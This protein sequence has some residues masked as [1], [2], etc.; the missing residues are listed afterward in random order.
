MYLAINLVIQ[1]LWQWIIGIVMM[2]LA[3][4]I[5]FLVTQEIWISA[6]RDLINTRKKQIT[7]GG[8][9]L[10]AVLSFFVI[11]N[12]QPKNLFFWHEFTLSVWQI[13]FICILSLGML[14]FLRQWHLKGI[15]VF[16][17][18]DVK[19]IIGV[20]ILSV[21][22]SLNKKSQ[23]ERATHIPV[24]QS[25]TTEKIIIA[26]SNSNTRG[27]FRVRHT[28]NTLS[29]LYFDFYYNAG[30]IQDIKMHNGGVKAGISQELF[31]WIQ[32]DPINISSYKV[33]CSVLEHAGLTI[34]T[35]GINLYTNITQYEFIFTPETKYIQ[36]QTHM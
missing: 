32:Q 34:G 16:T 12:Y 25:S 35:T 4:S 27:V 1:P 3:G 31:S 9:F 24:H 15:K 22:S 23:T 19:I 10:A 8:L 7:L 18:T 5:L 13:Y 29:C 28:V 26:A 6:K 33:S 17:R 2:L 36:Y 11:K 20:G 30:V 14:L 21:L